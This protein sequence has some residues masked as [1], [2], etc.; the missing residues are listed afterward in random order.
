MN[1]I[2]KMISRNKNLKKM[3]KKKLIPN[4]IKIQFQN[5]IKC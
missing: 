5:K 3:K 2:Y 1:K 4:H